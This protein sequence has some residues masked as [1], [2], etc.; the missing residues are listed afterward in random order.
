MEGCKGEEKD[1]QVTKG[2]MLA[3]K[4]KDVLYSFLLKHEAITSD[5]RDAWGRHHV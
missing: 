5:E 4:K 2:P 1:E 3:V